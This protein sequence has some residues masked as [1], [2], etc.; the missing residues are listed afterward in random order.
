MATGKKTH[1]LFV[2]RDMNA[3]GVEK[4]L[5]SLLSVLSPD[6]YEVDLGLIDYSGDF[7][8]MVP[9]WVNVR[10]IEPLHFRKDILINRLRALPGVLRSGRLVLAMRMIF[11]YGIAQLRRTLIPYYRAL[12][13]GDNLPKYDVAVSYQGPNELLDFFVAERVRADKKVAW[14]H[15]DVS[16]FFTRTRTVATLYPSFHRICVVSREA[17]SVFAGRFPSLAGSVRHFPNVINASLNARLASE[18]SRLRNVSSLRIVTVGRLEADKG[19]AEAM[20]V[21]VELKRRGVD[22]C[23]FFIGSGS[24]RDAMQKKAETCGIAEEVRFTGA[25]TNPYPYMKDCDVYVQPSRHE[26]FGLTIAEALGLG[27]PIVSSDTVGAREQLRNIQEA[28]IVEDFSASNVADAILKA[29]N[30]RHR[31]HNTDAMPSEALLKDIFLDK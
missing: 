21:A 25:L 14:I 31:S 19:V 12:L 24:L 22:F 2:A 8:H 10:V 29:S 4:S 26:G 1:I 15:F 7:L 5:I 9:D 30:F 13:P 3:G 28:I 27:A 17:L 18:H 16:R 6:D 20:D 23:W 11:W